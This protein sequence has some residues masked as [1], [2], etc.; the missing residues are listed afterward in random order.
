MKI[1]L[2]LTLLTLLTVVSALP[3]ADTSPASAHDLFKRKGGGGGGGRGSG[4]GSSGGGGGGGSSSS[5]PAGSTTSNTGG[6]SSGGTGVAPNYGGGRYYSGGATTPY[7]SGART[8]GGIA[9]VAILGVA[10]LAVFPGIWL[11][12][13]YAYPFSHPYSFRNYSNNQDE[14]KPVTCLCEQYAVCGCD[15]DNTN[16]TYFSDL[17][18]NGSTADL[19]NN[20]AVGL[21]NGTSTILVNGTLD[22]G[23]TAADSTSFGSHNIL[24]ML[25]LSGY[26]AM[27]STVAA[28]IMMT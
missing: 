16:S 14:T 10:A 22:N 5:R 20:V 9:P 28:T 21:V 4:G 11:Y 12:G 3:Q 25:Q 18:G 27:A 8:A 26:W 24:S 17:V 2:T 7:T 15:P 13:A 19:D 23:T 1:D 6:R